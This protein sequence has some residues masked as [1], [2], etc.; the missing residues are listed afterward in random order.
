MADDLAEALNR[1]ADTQAQ[2]ATG[3]AELVQ[4]VRATRGVCQRILDAITDPDGE[5]PAAEAL[6][7]VDAAVGRLEATQGALVPEVRAVVQF[8]NSRTG[9]A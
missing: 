3:Q 1:L 2:L 6:R 5:S 8:V 4:E 9:R 7:G